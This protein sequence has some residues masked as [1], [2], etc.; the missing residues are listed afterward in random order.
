MLVRLELVLALILVDSLT[1]AE[2]ARAWPQSHLPQL[3]SQ[4]SNTDNAQTGQSG[5]KSAQGSQL[6]STSRRQRQMA[7]PRAQSRV[8]QQQTDTSGTRMRWSGSRSQTPPP[9]PAPSSSAQMAGAYSQTTRF[10]GS[11]LTVQVHVHSYCFIAS[12][13]AVKIYSVRTT[14][15]MSTL[16]IRPYTSSSTSPSSLQR[17]TVSAVLLS[18]SNPR[19]LVVA[20][21]DGKV[22]LWDYLEGRLLRTLEMGAPVVH[23]TANANLPDQLYVALEAPGE[24]MVAEAPVKRMAKREKVPLVEDEPK[25]GVYLVSLRAARTTSDGVPTKADSSLPVPPARRVRLA[26]PRVVRALAL[27]PDGSVLASVNP[28][29]INLCRTSEYS[30]GFTQTVQADNESLTTIAFHPTENYFAT[31]N[32]KGQI[33]LWYNVLSSPASQVDTDGDVALSAPS[34]ADSATSTSVLHWHAHAVSSLAFTPNGAYLLSGGQE[35]VLVLWQLHTGH[36]EYVP[37]LGAPIATLSVLDGT[38]DS[39][40]QQVAARLR[41]GSVVFIGSQKLRIAKTISG[42]KAGASALLHSLRLSFLLT[43]YSLSQTPPLAPPSPPLGPTHPFPSP[44]TP[45]PPP[46]SSPPATPPPSNSTP[47]PPTRNSSS[48]R[49]RPQTAFRARPPTSL[50]SRPA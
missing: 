16:S 27:S 23:A 8:T 33:R 7:Q 2:R 46:S 4:Q 43:Q 20:S 19:Q 47:S 40:E 17:A 39:G 6:S 44:S 22:R 49:S 50:L 14:Q 35:A 1:L 15:L 41:D 42:L 34:A 31:G 24:A 12:G 28:H 13:S 25:A 30:R 36:Q 29:A 10:V 9:Q 18:P 48:S 21:T 11:S 38:S 3:H 32:R 45:P 26:V 5:S 37:R